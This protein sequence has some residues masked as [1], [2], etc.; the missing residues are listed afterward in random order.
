MPYGDAITFYPIR[1]MLRA[2]ARIGAADDLAAA[3]VKLHDAVRG[4]T[5]D[6]DVEAVAHRL[7][8]IAGLASA[9]DLLADVPAAELPD[10]LRWAIRRYFEGRAAS[11][12]SVLVF[13]DIHWGEPTL[14]ELI[15]HLGMARTSLFVLCLAR[16]EL[17]RAT[18]DLGYSSWNTA[19]STVPAWRE[20][21]ATPDR[22]VAGDRRPSRTTAV[23]SR[24]ACRRQSTIRRGVSEI[25]DRGWLYP[26]TRFA[27][28]RG[29]RCAG[30]LRAT[31]PAW[32]N[33]SATR[34]FA[35]GAEAPRTACRRCRPRRQ[36]GRAGDP[37]WRSTGSSSRRD[38]A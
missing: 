24:E 1:Q 2:D 14:L 19:H 17:V 21:H 12:P 6:P 4:A 31:D 25:A 18:A 3:R 36:R 11:G 28:A 34:S 22:G 5:Q 29:T 7:E 35:V 16:Q 32:P 23:G 10:E 27:L 26:S 38:R 9:H 13:E 8:V 15:E 20:R 37:R 30:P 33:R